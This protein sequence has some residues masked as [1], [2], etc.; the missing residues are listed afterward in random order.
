MKRL[1]ISSIGIPIKSLQGTRLRRSLSQPFRNRCTNPSGC[2]IARLNVAAG[3]NYSCENKVSK[4]FLH[5][6]R[7][8]YDR[9]VE[10]KDF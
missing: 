9:K 10:T 8:P 6:D 7:D 3:R 5:F 1:R 2:D 4:K